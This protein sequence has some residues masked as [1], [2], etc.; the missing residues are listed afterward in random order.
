MRTTQPRS[1][2]HALRSVAMAAV[3]VLLAAGAH[4]LGGGLLPALPVFA[5]LLALTGL[6]ATLAT[7]FKLNFPA[8]T[9]LLGGSQLALHEAFTVLAPIDAAAPT[10][11]HHSGSEMLAP[12]LDP[13]AHIHE[14]G[15]AAGALMFAAHVVAT[16]GSAAALAKGE[17]ALWQLAAWLR[18]L[19]ALPTL[20][21]KPDA[22]ATPPAAGTPDVFIPRP[23]RN[24]RQDSRRGPPAAVVL[25]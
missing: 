12:V 5:A 7:R 15:T 9:V 4:V 3:I 13:A 16:I 2:F 18:P 19:V 11:P 21:F 24:L 14:L 22:G 20:I 1:P 23:W 8:M 17:D 25:P 6:A 10:G